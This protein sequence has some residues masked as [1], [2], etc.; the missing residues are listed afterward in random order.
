MEN[1]DNIQ[2]LEDLKNKMQI[3]KENLNKCEIIDD[4]Q[5]MQVTRLSCEP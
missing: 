3:L 1:K 4:E 5:I 2:E